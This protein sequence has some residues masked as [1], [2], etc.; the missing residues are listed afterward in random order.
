M[1]AQQLLH[2][3]QGSFFSDFQDM[4]ELLLLGLY[5]NY[6]N[7][8]HVQEFWNFVEYPEKKFECL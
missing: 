6:L 5:L 3:L 7:N 4:A 8:L 2:L 1:S